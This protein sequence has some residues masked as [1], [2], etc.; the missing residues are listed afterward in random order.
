M[1]AL[2]NDNQPGTDDC[3]SQLFGVIWGRHRVLIAHQDERRNRDRT[4]ARSRVRA[5]DDGFR[6]PGQT[7]DTDRARHTHVDRPQG[8]VVLVRGM[9]DRHEN[10]CHERLKVAR[11]RLLHQG[12]PPFGLL[13]RVRT[14]GGIDQGKRQM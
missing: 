6:L 7:L 4:K 10:G 12:A 8:W 1:A 3:S 11:L 14:R 13:R 9:K 2:R 5:C